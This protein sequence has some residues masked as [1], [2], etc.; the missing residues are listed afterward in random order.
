MLRLIGYWKGR[1]GDEYPFPQ[2]VRA[3]Y[4]PDLREKVLAYLESGEV[5]ARYRGDSWC[6]FGCAEHNGS[7][8][9]TD[10]RWVWPQGLA[11]YVS[12]H[13]VALP[14]E[15]LRD[16]ADGDR[17][18]AASRSLP[19]PRS[20]V[21]QSYWIDWARS[22][23]V[24]AVEALLE[25]AR[26]NASRACEASLE[27]IAIQRVALE[28]I[29]TTSCV[30]AAC[31]RQVVARKAFCA[32]CLAERERATVQLAVEGRELKRVIDLLPGVL[33]NQPLPRA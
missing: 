3:E 11:H 12:H 5:F 18:A 17:L 25:E 31:G 6:R 26:A 8:E 14:P 2:E 28:G 20:E 15:F 13:A 23:R 24:G 1:L 7:A 29:G 33:A 21:D 9:L 16:V 32:R 10:G 19:S 22:Y 30:T 4:A 27:A